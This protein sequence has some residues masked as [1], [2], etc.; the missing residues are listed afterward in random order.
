[1]P[2]FE[3]GVASYVYGC[4]TISV[5]FP[6]DSHGIPH[7]NCMNCELFR[8]STQ[9]CGINHRI[10]EFPDKYIGSYCPLG[11]GEPGGSEEKEITNDQS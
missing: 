8:R 9:R 10:C 7:V 5:A 1:M 11:F 4:C 3:S 2:I 6:V